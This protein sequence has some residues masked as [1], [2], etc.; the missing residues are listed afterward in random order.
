MVG[1][2]LI[3]MKQIFEDGK[4]ILMNSFLSWSKNRE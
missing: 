1:E 2:I 3:Q 4:T